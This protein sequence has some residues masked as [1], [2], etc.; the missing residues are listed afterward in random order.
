KTS[1]SRYQTGSASHV[2]AH[3]GAGSR[4][5]RTQLPYICEAR[6]A[7]GRA[8]MC[9]DKPAKTNMTTS[10]F[11]SLLTGLTLA[12]LTASAATYSDATGDFTGG[13]SDLDIASVSVAN[14][15]TTLTF[16]INVVGNPQNNT[17]YDYYVGISR[18]LYGGVGGNL[19]GPGGWGKN[20]Q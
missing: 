5:W 2:R 3:S 18:N 9:V 7:A 11:T 13:N 10:T 14:D 19:N 17:W 1:P 16:T 4:C 8:V 6:L 20:I 12:G 15:A